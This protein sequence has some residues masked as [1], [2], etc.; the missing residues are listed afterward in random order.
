MAETSEEDKIIKDGRSG[1]DRHADEYFS[2]PAF[3]GEMLKTVFNYIVVR[4]QSWTEVV[5][6]VKPRKRDLPILRQEL[7]KAKTRYPELK[8][9]RLS[10]GNWVILDTKKPTLARRVIT[11]AM[12]VAHSAVF[13]CRY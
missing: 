8:D 6:D 3:T 1:R 4:G 5:C 12:S 10:R 11:R 2:S 13:C 7:E 9:I